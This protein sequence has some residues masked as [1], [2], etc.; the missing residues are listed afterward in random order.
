MKRV[1]VID[2][3]PLFK[4]K[5]APLD[6]PQVQ[7]VR[8]GNFYL[9]LLDETGSIPSDSYV[10]DPESVFGIW[11]SDQMYENKTPCLHSTLS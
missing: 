11:N 5:Q 10:V 8:G 3:V 6:T 1:N 9:T 7:E 4:L 2:G